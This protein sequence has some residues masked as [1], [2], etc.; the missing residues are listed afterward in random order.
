M[1]VTVDQAVAGYITLRDKRSVLK[2]EYEEQDADLRTKM[3]K[4][5]VFLLR[6]LDGVGANSLNTD[7]G[8]AY[9]SEDVRASCG[10]WD[11]LWT[12]IQTTGR[13]D[14]L[15]KRVSSKAVREFKEET[16]ELP[17]G[18]SIHSERVVRIRRS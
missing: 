15:E 5:E 7:H 10:D 3:E 16:G 13:F 12:M 9:I 11:A 14:F 1:S 8:T 18:V 17:P 6:S 2:R 4:I